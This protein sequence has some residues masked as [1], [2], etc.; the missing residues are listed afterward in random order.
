MKSLHAHD[1]KRMPWKNGGGET[2]EIA[3]FPA[4]ASVETFEWRISM[5]TVANDGPFSIFR[6]IDRTLS[7]LQGNGMALAIE[8]DNPVLL[9]KASPPLPFPADVRVHA[10][11]PDGAIVDLN[12]MTRRDTWRHR[13]HRHVGPLSSAETTATQTL[14]LAVGPVTVSGAGAVHH[15]KDMDALM[16]EAGLSISVRPDK[17]EGSYF[18]IELIRL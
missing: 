10:T 12:V 4:D 17:P 1:Y 18:L 16:L 9:T 5:A 3:I 11:L 6:G 7:I 8:N 14:L 15:L 2:V 13:V